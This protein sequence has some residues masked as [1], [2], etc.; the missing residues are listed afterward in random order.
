MRKTMNAETI[1]IVNMVAYVIYFMLPAYL[2]NVTALTFGGGT[3]LDFGG[4]YKDGYRLLGNGVT[5]KGT[6]IGSLFG[7]SI[8]IVQGLIIGNI[9]QGF[10]LG[11]TLA[12]GALMGD[13]AGSFIKRRLKIDSGK[14]A[15]ILDQLDFVVG[16]LL[17]SSLVQPLPSFLIF[18]ILIITLILH[19][20]ANILAYSLGIKEVWY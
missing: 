7:T 18:L 12:I 8:G 4:Y 5:W 9:V 16:A 17:L 15:P 2:A 1:N 20:S 13:A 14:P 10:L 11:F 3:P 6:I 19:L